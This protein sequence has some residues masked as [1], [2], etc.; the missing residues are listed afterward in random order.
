MTWRTSRLWRGR[1]LNSLGLVVLLGLLLW[2]VRV[3]PESLVLALFVMLLL[4]LV[5]GLLMWSHADHR[6]ELE[7]ASWH[8][9]RPADS[10]GPMALDYRLVRLR[11]DLRDALQRD[12][13]PDQIHALV[14]DLALDQLREQHGVDAR[15]DPEAA[16]ALLDP[17]VWDYLTSPPTTTARRSAR[18]LAH[19]LDQ[20]EQL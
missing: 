1:V 3:L 17:Q 6:G 9:A 19:V 10:S 20:L 14:C 4:V 12:D 5:T 2:Y 8:A 16:E 18:Q 15:S 11:R 13:R 7:R